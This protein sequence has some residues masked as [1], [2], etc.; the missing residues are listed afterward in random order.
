MFCILNY[1]I[2]LLLYVLVHHRTELLKAVGEYKLH[3]IIAIHYQLQVMC[4]YLALMQQ[5]LILVSVFISH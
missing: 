3:C 4:K 1:F 2:Q 5:L